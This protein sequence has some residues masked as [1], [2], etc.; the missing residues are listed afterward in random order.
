MICPVVSEYNSQ[1][2]TP[3]KVFTYV[4]LLPEGSKDPKTDRF[5]TSIGERYNVIAFHTN[6]SSAFWKKP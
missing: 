2:I 5:E 6:N 4:E 1:T 3:G